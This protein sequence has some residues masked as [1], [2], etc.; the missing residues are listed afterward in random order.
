MVACFAMLRIRGAAPAG[1]GHVS[2]FPKTAMASP[3]AP[4]RSRSPRTAADS[5][6]VIAARAL[7]FTAWARRNAR[8]VIA[9]AVVAA[10]AIGTLLWY[11]IDRTRQAARAAAEYMQVEQTVAT[12]PSAAPAALQNFIQRRDGSPEADEARLTL[13]QLHLTAGDAARAVQVLQPFDRRIGQ[14]P[15][16]AQ[17][18]LLLGAAQAE[19]GQRDA[20]ITTYLRVADQAQ[21]RFRQ[22]EALSQAALLR[23]QGGDAVGAA[24]L[25]R[26]LV[27]MAEEGTPERSVYEMRLAEAEGQALA[28]GG[29]PAAGTR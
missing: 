23:Q 5:D 2:V 1:A 22:E 7:Q 10:V 18:A 3:S 25:Y 8:L 14:G 28:Q 9:G 21:T 15:L 19:A 6:D 4:P 27:D 24:E 20:A 11:R 12:N 17:G 16:G 29:A 13:A 26:R